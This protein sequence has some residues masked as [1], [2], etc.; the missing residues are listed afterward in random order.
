M[1]APFTGGDP[2]ARAHINQLV[3]AV[4]K[5]ERFGHD[6]YITVTQ[7]PTGYIHGLNVDALLPRIPKPVLPT[8]LDPYVMLPADRTVDVAQTDS[9]DRKLGFKL[10]PAG[11]YDASKD[12]VEWNGP[13]VIYDH[14][15]HMILRVWDRVA[16]YDKNG[17]LVSLSA[18]TDNDY[19]VDTPV[20]CV[21][22]PIDGGSSW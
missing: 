5:L 14:A 16:V 19:I 9:W 22:S 7:G 13:R 8:P 3:S 18:E 2:K 12:G 17:G 21:I 10:T 4:N 6:S 15:T 1:I 11:A 20:D